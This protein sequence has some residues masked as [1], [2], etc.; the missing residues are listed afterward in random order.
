MGR[1]I[2]TTSLATAIRHLPDRGDPSPGHCSRVQHASTRDDEAPSS[3]PGLA[4]RGD[5]PSASLFSK[6]CRCK[7]DLCRTARGYDSH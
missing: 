3:A 1:R 7:N 2:L 6:N 4:P 5:A